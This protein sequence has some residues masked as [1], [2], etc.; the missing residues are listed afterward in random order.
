MKDSTSETYLDHVL[1]LTIPTRDTRGRAVRIGPA[2]DRILSAH[3]YP[4][5]LRALLAEALV[6]TT[7]MGSLLK[8]DGDQLTLQAQA[9][10][11]PVSLLVCDYRDGEL[12][13]YCEFDRSEAA[14][15]GTDLSLAR[16]FGS[17]Y[18]AMTFDLARAQ[19]RY[20]GIVPLEGESI[21]AACEQYFA[22]SEQVPTMIRIALSQ[23]GGAMIGGGLLL[24]HLPD[25][26][27][28][29]E[30]L[31]ARLDH[32]Q[33][34]HVSVMG[35]SVRG[36]ELTDPGLSLEALIWRLFHEEDEVRINRGPLI[37]RGCRCTSAH[38]EEVLSRFPDDERDAMRDDDRII[39]VDCAFCSRAFPLAT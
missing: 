24:Q 19:E 4:P 12:R 25:G 23:D 17:G 11:G 31:H 7:L 22:Q 39:T 35:G 9:E 8:D 2:L 33:W 10:G 14:D 20:Q 3:A 21:A 18:L 30:R 28:G 29:R 1:G 5:P 16:L 38:F 6:V 34:E 15:L 27:E 32:P 26:E 36:D 37:H 13:G